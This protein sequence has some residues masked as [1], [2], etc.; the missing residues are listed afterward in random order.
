MNN[1]SKASAKYNKE[2]TTQV[3]LRLNKKTDADIIEILN[4]VESKQG[5][6]KGLIRYDAEIENMYSCMYEYLR[7]S[8]DIISI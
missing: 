7:K 3:L 1:R 2:N 8:V 5:Y 4:K 6:I